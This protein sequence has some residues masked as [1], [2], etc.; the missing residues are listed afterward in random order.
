MKCPHCEKTLT[1]KQVAAMMGSMGKGKAK[2]RTS[3]QARSAVLKRWETYRAKKQK[4]LDGV[5][6]AIRSPATSPEDREMLRRAACREQ[7]IDFD[8][9]DP[10]RD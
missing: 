5:T 8:A 10:D 2:A 3:E 9:P 4:A 7:G 1:R 6:K